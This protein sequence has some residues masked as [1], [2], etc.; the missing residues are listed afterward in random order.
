VQPPLWRSPAWEL[1]VE[2]YVV[3]YRWI[4]A[5]PQK[6]RLAVAIVR[7]YGLSDAQTASAFLNG[8]RPMPERLQL[9]PNQQKCGHCT[10]S[11]QIKRFHEANS[12]KV[13]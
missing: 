2:K 10:A 9:P 6:W 7:Q 8:H 11:L 12:Q 5:R 1:Q 3:S 13:V 4:P